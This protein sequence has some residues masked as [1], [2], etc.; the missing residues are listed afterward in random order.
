MSRIAHITA[1]EILDSRGNPTIRVTTHTTDG[2]R[3]V[4]DVPSGIST[5]TREA[6]ELRDGDPKRYGGKGVLRA[7]Q[8][9]HKIISPELL[10]KSIYEQAILDQYMI[11]LDGTSNKS[12]LGANAILGVSLSIAK[13]AA[14]T[15][16]TSLFRYL[17]RADGITLPT[18]MINII[19]GGEHAQNNLAFQEFMICPH[20]LATFR[21]SLRAGSEIF[22]SLKKLL[23]KKNYIVSV[24]DEGGFAPNFT[25]PEEALDCIVLAIVDA[26]YTPKKE[27]SIALD[28]AASYFY[29]KERDVYVD[30]RMGKEF[31]RTTEQQIDYLLSLIQQYPINSIEDGLAEQDWN[32]W[33]HLTQKLRGKV[34]LIGD[35]IFCTNSSLLQ[36]GIEEKVATSILIKPNQIGTLTE[37]FEVARLAIENGYNLVASHRSGDTEDSCIA[38]IGIAMGSTRVKFGSVCRSERTAKYNRL[39]EIEL[40]LSL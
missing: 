36:K 24:G 6:L 13:A 30:N 40:E 3:G 37:T 9:I 1:L 33:K 21:E 26:G 25:S 28:C 39:L 2:Y 35:D 22:Y 23:C 12:H 34:E 19:N 7:I 18:P 10:G 31:F 29:K 8:N 5:G 38:D 14:N 4:A 15:A 17:N 16:R 32:G 11:D 20:G 27:V